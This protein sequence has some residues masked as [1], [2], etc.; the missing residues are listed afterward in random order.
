MRERYPDVRATS[1]DPT[2]KR[3]QTSSLGL[4]D[5]RILKG[6]ATCG[7]CPGPRGSKGHD[8]RLADVDPVGQWP[9]PAAG[10][11]NVQEGDPIA[12]EPD[13]QARKG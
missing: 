4:S 10:G 8:Q 12:A 9:A 3:L 13:V 6:W 7:A 11:S 2:G 1:V 5:H